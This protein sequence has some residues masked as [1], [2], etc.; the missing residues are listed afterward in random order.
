MHK[1]NSVITHRTMC[2]A[3]ERA[4]NN[5]PTIRSSLAEQGDLRKGIT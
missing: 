5:V 1:F 3:W 2:S 4:K